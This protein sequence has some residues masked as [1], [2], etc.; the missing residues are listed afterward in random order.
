VGNQ[1][2]FHLQKFIWDFKTPIKSYGQISERGWRGH[3]LWQ[4]QT[5]CV[6]FVDNFWLEAWNLKWIFRDESWF[7]F[8][9]K[10]LRK[11]YST[12]PKW[13]LKFY[14]AHNFYVLTM[15][16]QALIFKLSHTLRGFVTNNEFH[17]KNNLSTLYSH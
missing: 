4:F 11:S 8:S 7:D 2:K 13:S 15:S 10:V 16:S 17:Y 9:S 5:S 14:V 1:A 6:K 12:M 3:F